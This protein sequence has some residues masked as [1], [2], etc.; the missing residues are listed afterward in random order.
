[1]LKTMEIRNS[2]FHSFRLGSKPTLGRLVT[3]GV[4]SEI[5]R[6]FGQVTVSV[7]S[8]R[9]I[10]WIVL[11]IL[12]HLVVLSYQFCS[13]PAACPLGLAGTSSIDSK[14]SFIFYVLFPNCCI[15]FNNPRRKYLVILWQGEVVQGGDICIFFHFFYFVNNGRDNRNY[16]S[17]QSPRV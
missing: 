14:R 10:V 1:M 16:R 17:R 9:K 5:D 6:W 13:C 15:F 11:Y 12:S 7:S 2:W 3:F 8:F 4:R